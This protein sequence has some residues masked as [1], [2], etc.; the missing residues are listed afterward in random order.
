MNENPQLV[1]TFD[2]APLTPHPITHTAAAAKVFQGHSGV[3]RITSLIFLTWNVRVYTS[4]N[5]GQAHPAAIYIILTH[6]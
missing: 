2:V 6:L 1:N 5:I 4:Q 3:A